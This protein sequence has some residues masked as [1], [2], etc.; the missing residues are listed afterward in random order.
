VVLLPLAGVAGTE[1]HVRTVLTIM[2][3]TFSLSVRRHAELL[4]RVNA[5]A[6]IQQ[7]GLPVFAVNGREGGR[8]D[9]DFP[10]YPY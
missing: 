9:I 10:C 6:G 5:G 2:D 1:N 8:A 7:D 3:S 4:Q